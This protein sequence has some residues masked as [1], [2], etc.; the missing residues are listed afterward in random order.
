MMIMI[1]SMDQKDEVLREVMQV[2]LSEGLAGLQRLKDEGKILDFISSDEVLKIL[3]VGHID[4]C[5][6]E[7]AVGTYQ[8]LGDECV[9]PHCAYKWEKRIDNPKCCPRC[10]QR[11]D[12]K[13]KGKK[14]IGDKN[15][16]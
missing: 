11:L 12:S 9:C 10:K 5:H 14:P 13:P 6:V 7:M 2:Y 16:I 3:A 1:C 8:N 15:A 4:K